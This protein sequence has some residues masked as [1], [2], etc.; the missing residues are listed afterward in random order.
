MIYSLLVF[1]CFYGL[2]VG[3]L[4]AWKGHCFP[5]QVFI[6]CWLLS[7]TATPM[8]VYVVLCFS[9]HSSFTWIKWWVYCY[10]FHWAEA[11]WVMWSAPQIDSSSSPC[12]QGQLLVLGMC[13]AA[14][15]VGLT[16]RTPHLSLSWGK[17]QLFLP[18]CM[19][20]FIFLKSSIWV[21]ST[22]S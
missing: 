9:S 8:C 4:N 17:L 21:E 19:R 3:S 1:W 22:L 20:V 6:F 7:L 12:F 14:S 10:V 13:A 18:K 15:P 16:V 2:R 11:G 5:H